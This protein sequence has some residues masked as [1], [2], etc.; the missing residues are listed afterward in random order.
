MTM[1]QKNILVEQY[2]RN[3]AIELNKK[4]PNIVSEEKITKTIDMFKNSNDDFEYIKKQIDDLVK[5][6]IGN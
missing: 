6:L 1:E 4:Y 2:I 5:E 3:L